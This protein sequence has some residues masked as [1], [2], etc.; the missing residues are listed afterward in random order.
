M[1]ERGSEVAIRATSERDQP[2]LRAWFRDH[3]GSEILVLRETVYHPWRLPGFVAEQGPRP[4]GLLTYR[5][6]DDEG[7]IMTLDSLLSGRGIGSALIT[8]AV[9]TARAAGC[10]RLVVVTTNDNM[11]A[12]R[13]YQKRGFA[14]AALRPGAVTRGRRLKPEIPLRGDDDIPIRDELEL[15]M[16]LTEPHSSGG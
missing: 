16:I 8:R 1:T 7:E 4:V 5:L 6:A 15:H 13:F 14:L 11:N 2:W 10:R 3:W 9:T 12:L